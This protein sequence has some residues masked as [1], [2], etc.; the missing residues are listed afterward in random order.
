MVSEFE[1]RNKQRHRF[2]L[3]RLI[4]AEVT[5]RRKAHA[6][7]IGQGRADTT[8]CPTI[9]RQFFRIA[10]SLRADMIF[11]K[12]ICLSADIALT[13]ELV[14]RRS[15]KVQRSRNSLV[16]SPCARASRTNS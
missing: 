2:K 11:G 3:E 5:L 7:G 16:V 8:T 10:S 9:R 13:A 6:L 15:N 1:R 12:D 14:G 4:Q